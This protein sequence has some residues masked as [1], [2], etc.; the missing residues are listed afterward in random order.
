[1][2]Y[3]IGISCPVNGI[4]IDFFGGSGSTLM[5][6]QETDRICY[7]MELDPKYASVILRRYAQSYGEAGIVCERNGQQLP[8]SELVKQ[9]ERM[10]KGGTD[11]GG[12]EENAK[13]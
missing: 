1:M 4:V 11:L 6:C 2:A 3:P 9:V 12:T 8:Y 13:P 10:E 7:M 5:A